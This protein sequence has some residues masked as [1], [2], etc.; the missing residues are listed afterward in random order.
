[1][2]AAP[3]AQAGALPGSEFPL[4]AA[5]RDGGTNFAVASEV[6]DGMV[7]CLFDQAD[8]GTRIPNCEAGDKV[9][10][11]PRSIVVLRSPR[12]PEIAGAAMP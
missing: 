11:G 8:T 9:T 7:L 12:P 3:A 4:G 1:M 2:S 5:V 10:V 6:A